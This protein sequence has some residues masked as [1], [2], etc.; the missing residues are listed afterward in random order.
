MLGPILRR[1]YSRV[2]NR[3]LQCSVYSARRMFNHECLPPGQVDHR[4]N[5]IAFRRRS[6]CTVALWFCAR[7]TI[8][9]LPRLTR[10]RFA[11]VNVYI[12]RKITLRE[13]PA[14]ALLIIP[15]YRP[16]AER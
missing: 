5:S 9:W 1:H 8:R 4:Q 12:D 10:D 7:A 11:I 15:F 6:N 2:H 16:P 14:T 13:N 3:V